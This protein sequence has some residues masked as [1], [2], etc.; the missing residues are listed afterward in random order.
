[1]MDFFTWDNF[2]EGFTH[3]AIAIA[4][5]FSIIVPTVS[6][7]LAFQ[8]FPLYV[9]VSLVAAIFVVLMFLIGAIS[10]A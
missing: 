7:I 4:F 3:L 5:A 8:F 9:A 2:K 6:L 10:N 1:M